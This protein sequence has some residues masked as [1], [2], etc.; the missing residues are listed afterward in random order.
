MLLPSLCEQVSESHE[1]RE[2]IKESV[3]VFVFNHRYNT[4]DGRG[5]FHRKLTPPQKL[6]GSIIYNT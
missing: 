1:W 2:A 3:F 5:E 6:V 4:Q